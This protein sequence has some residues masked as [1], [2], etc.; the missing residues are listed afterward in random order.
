MVR[1][2]LQISWTHE[3]HY[4]YLQQMWRKVQHNHKICCVKLRSRNYQPSS[5][6]ITEA[7]FLPGKPPSRTRK[8]PQIIIRAP[9]QI[10]IYRGGN[11]LVWGRSQLELKIWRSRRRWGG[12]FP[13]HISGVKPPPISL[14]NDQLPFVRG[15]GGVGLSSH[16]SSIPTDRPQL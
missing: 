8:S 16:D 4:L 6:V 9:H 13:G 12:L 14:A 15:G 10:N 3:S 1:N 7:T 11:C 5:C 2:W